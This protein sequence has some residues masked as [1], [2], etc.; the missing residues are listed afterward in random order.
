MKI[1]A[2]VAILIIAY[3]AYAAWHLYSYAQK[4]PVLVEAAIPFTI[5]EPT[6]TKSILVLGDSTA[7]GVGS[8]AKLTVAGR[9]ASWLNA[10]VDN[11]SKS[12][13]KTADLAGQ[14]AKS[15]NAR[16]DLI[17]FHIGAND[18][19]RFESLLQAENNLD[20]ALTTLSKQSDKIVFLTAGDIGDAQ[21]WPWPLSTAYTYRTRELRTLF[22]AQAKKHNATYIDIFSQ[23]DIFGSDPNKYYAPDGLHLSGDGYGRWFEF[24]QKAIKERWPELTAVQ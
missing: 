14:I 3:G 22:M 23:G 19:I 7:A 20:A 6:R 13:A 10:N 11:F 17:V 21:I 15:K 8:P 5:H 16:Y 18:V 4:S 1:L 2:L 24:V 12:G 9:L